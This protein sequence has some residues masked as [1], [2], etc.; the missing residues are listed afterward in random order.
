MGKPKRCLKPSNIF[1]KW[2]KPQTTTTTEAPTYQNYIRF[3]IP[4]IPCP[5][6][7]TTTTTQPPPPPTGNRDTTF[8]CDYYIYINNNNEDSI[9]NYRPCD[10]S[11]NINQYVK[12][13]DGICSSRLY[14]P[15]IV[16]GNGLLLY[17]NSCG[18]GNPF[19][20]NIT[21]YFTKNG[22]LHYIDSEDFHKLQ[23]SL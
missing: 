3:P 23:H 21:I 6:H 9:V 13:M 22:Y 1:K 12:H 8:N 7:T 2:L 18:I 20:N 16:A 15:S 11:S 17:S 5:L 19:N 4:N 14:S 10:S